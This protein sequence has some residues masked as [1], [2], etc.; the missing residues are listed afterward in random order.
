LGDLLAGLGGCVVVLFLQVG[1]CLVV[2]AKKNKEAEAQLLSKL[3]ILLLINLLPGMIINTRI[4]MPATGPPLIP[5]LLIP[6]ITASPMNVNHLK[7]M[8]LVFGL[9]KTFH[10]HNGIIL[11][12]TIKTFVGFYFL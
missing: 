12:N 4:R 9:N 1:F 11:I 2:H 3:L 6:T 10:T 7:D 5:L 8:S